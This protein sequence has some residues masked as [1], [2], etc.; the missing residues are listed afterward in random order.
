MPSRTVRDR[1]REEYF[2][3]L[4]TIRLVTEDLEIEIR[5][6]LRPIS[7][8]LDRFEQI[9]VTSRIKEC[10]SAVD[11]LERRQEGKLF[12]ETNSYTLADLR[13]LAGVRVLAFP[14]SRLQEIDRSLRDIFRDVSDRPWTADP[15][16]ENDETLAFKYWGYSLASK[17]I[18]GEYQIVSALTGL[19]WEIEHPALYKPSPHW[20]GVAREL[21]M[22]VRSREVL[23][24]L[25]AFEEEFERLV[26][27][28]TSHGQAPDS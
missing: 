28:A 20:K 24:A 3:L 18:M 5:H 10:E 12:D 9:Q 15:V 19:F 17:K 8:T 11:S 26:R 1:L 6:R 14:P 2:A 22:Q 13:D 4:P 7:R 16:R 21:A 27:S 23:V 25:R